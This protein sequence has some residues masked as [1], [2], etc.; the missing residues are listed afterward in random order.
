MYSGLALLLDV[1]SP[2]KPNGYGVIFIAGS[3]WSSPLAY[4]ARQ[5][6]ET[7]EAGTYL[8]P[9]VERGFTVFALNHRSVPRFLYPAAVEDVQRAVRFIRLNARRFAIDPDRIGAAGLSSGGHLASM[10]GVLDGKGDPQD[11]DPVNRESAKVQCVVALE[12]ATDLLR[13]YNR[14]PGAFHNFLGVAANSGP[15]MLP[16]TSVEYRKFEEASPIHHVTRDD[17]PFLLIHGDTD[18]IVP[19]KHSELMEQ[20]LR[21]AGV[22]VK[23]LR[24]PGGGHGTTFHG[25]G[26]KSEDNWPDYMTEMVRWFDAHLVGLQRT[27][28]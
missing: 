11:A 20:A 5:L 9:L 13:G 26:F 24:V 6:K 2:E 18:Q 21:T 25:P 23:L 1:H 15:S 17:A 4:D 19:F 7:S 12:A 28:K 8:K 16:K 14:A 10:L 22:E 27:P 3:G